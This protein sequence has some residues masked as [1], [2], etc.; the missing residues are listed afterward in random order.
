LRRPGS[1]VVRLSVR[2]SFSGQPHLY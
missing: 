1:A 2:G